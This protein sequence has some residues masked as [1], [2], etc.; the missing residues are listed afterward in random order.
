MSHQCHSCNSVSPVESA[1]CAGSTSC[2]CTREFPTCGNSYNAATNYGPNYTRALRQLQATADAIP[3]RRHTASQLPTG[4]GCN[5]CN[6]CGNCGCNGC[7]GC[8]SCGNCGCNSC[9]SCGCCNDCGGC[10]SCGCGPD[11]CVQAQYYGY[12]TQ[13]TAA[14]GSL[15]FSRYSPPDDGEAG[16]TL[17]LPAGRF[18]ISY[19]VNASR[20]GAADAETLGVAP[21]ING[22]AFPRGGSFATVP[23]G[24][25]AALSA[26]FIVT[27]TN[28]VNTL[29]FYNT[30]AA[31]TTYQLLN[32]SIARA[33]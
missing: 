22:V 9:G 1:G 6:G 13:Q 28:A 33:C 18:L 24:G 16:T 20:T 11:P 31:E 19:S 12:P 29:G 32:I 23:A 21:R 4:C 15:V 2:F 17:N 3:V 8:G 5:G 27:L 25:S 30:G 14:G 26:S 7:S 10:G